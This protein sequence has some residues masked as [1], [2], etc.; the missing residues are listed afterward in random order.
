MS[1]HSEFVFIALV[2]VFIALSTLTPMISPS[3]AQQPPVAKF[4]FTPTVPL[5]NQTVTFDASS[6]YD[7]SGT[8]LLYQWNFGDGNLTGL[9]VPTTTHTYS[10][11]GNYTVTLTVTDNQPL[12]GNTS[13][14]VA[15][16][17]YPTASFTFS[18][19]RAL[20]NA[21]VTFDASASTQNG[22]SIVSYYWDFG[23][24]NTANVSTP[25]TTHAY[26]AVG[27]YVI[28][29]N[30]TNNYGF[31][32]SCS[33][34]ITIMNPPIADYTFTPAWP[35]VGQTVTF[36]ASASTPD[37][38][39][40]VSYYWDFGDGQNGT[41]V[42]ITHAYATYGNFTVT[43]NV[44]DSND[45]SSTFSSQ[46]NVRQYPTANI[47]YTP[48][49]P[50]YVNQTV[51]FNAS[52]STPNGGSIVTYSWNF[53]DGNTGLGAVVNHAYSNYGT[54]IVNLTVTNSGQL[55]NSIVQSMRVIIDPVANFAYTP[56]YVA[57]ET[58]VVFNAS[59]SY[60][61]DGAS[62]VAYTW[63]F[64][65]GNITTQNNPLITH[66]YAAIGVYNV[67]LTVT[68][69]DGLTA[70]ATT[71]VPVYT[72]VPIINVAITQITK[73]AYIPNYPGNVTVADANFGDIVNINVTAANEG[74]VNETFTVSV[75]Y[76]NYTM[77]IQTVTNIAP[78]SSQ[79]LQFSLNTTS[80]PFG[81]YNITAVASTILGQTN[82]TGN[83]LNGGLLIVTTSGD[84]TGPNGLPSL[85][86]DIRDVNLVAKAYGS[87]PVDRPENWNPICDVTRHGQ[88]DIRD[89]SAVAKKYGWVG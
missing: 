57:V 34:S 60:N 31:S 62:L 49:L 54:Y 45:L 46:F 55:S 68:D 56:Y 6:S 11:V 7:P 89:V 78:N 74:T 65:D 66:T 30:V 3:F 29:L 52:A 5:V 35:I 87:D 73:S 23:D 48:S 25:I 75:Y 88:V 70:N 58:P 1:K 71:I 84:I 67:S 53:G 17:W 81:Y 36:N 63:N 13:A 43:L 18:P 19:T 44:T 32:D 21:I 51:T 69:T 2:T 16:T 64:G 41:G 15:V 72:T 85:K 33:S 27:T 22:G 40:I 12:S 59:Q 47:T 24:G 61:P 38:G 9:S 79:I 42:L 77:G 37:G 26:S 80:V 39:P 10:T 20:V 82:T 28:T 14:T 4:V 86:I 76:G 50:L 83:T 8:I